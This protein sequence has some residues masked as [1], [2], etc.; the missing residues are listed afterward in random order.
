MLLLSLDLAFSINNFTLWDCEEETAKQVYGENIGR[1][2]LQI[3]PKIFEDLKLP[4]QEV[5]IFAVNV[6]VGYSTGLR[7][8]VTMA[9]TYAQAADKPLVTYT[10]YEALLYNLSLEGKFLVVFKI[11]RYFVGGF[12]EKRGKNLIGLDYPF[13]LKGDNLGEKLSSADGIVIPV[14]LEKTF[15]ETFKEVLTTSVFNNRESVIYPVANEILSYT[16][17][18]LACEKFKRGEVAEILKVEPLYF[19]PPV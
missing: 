1:K 15:T 19:R 9:K 12:W 11:S 14:S 18:A 10:S 4:I 7:I 3:F 17:A 5:D 8:G 2:A 16:G 6:G 13:I